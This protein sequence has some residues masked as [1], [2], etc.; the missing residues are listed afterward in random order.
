MCLKWPKSQ[1]F[2]RSENDLKNDLVLENT[3]DK[4]DSIIILSLLNW[5]NSVL[6]A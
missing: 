3:Q 1:F 5:S 6:S 2:L 4:L